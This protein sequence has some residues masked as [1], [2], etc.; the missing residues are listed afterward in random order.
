MKYAAIRIPPFDGAKVLAALFLLATGLLFFSTF[1]APPAWWIPAPPNWHWFQWDVERQI[2][3]PTCLSSMPKAEKKTCC[4]LVKR[5]RSV[6]LGIF[7]FWHH[8]HLKHANNYETKDRTQRFEH[9]KSHG[10]GS[11]LITW[12]LPCIHGKY[13]GMAKLIQY[14]FCHAV[15]VLWYS[16]GFVMPLLVWRWESGAHMNGFIA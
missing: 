13:D 9:G 1:P 3:L 16:M 7:R 14:D 2:S 10:Y 5:C 8:F 12:V 6:F 15:W 4:W 11:A